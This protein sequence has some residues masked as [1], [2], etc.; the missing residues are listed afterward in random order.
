MG[1]ASGI[2]AAYLPSKFQPPPKTATSKTAHNKTFRRRRIP[3]PP[4]FISTNPTHVNP[5]HLRDLYT[6]SN[7]SCHRFPA[8][9]AD[10]RP[11]PVDL[12]KLRIA[13]SHSCIVVSVF[14]KPEVVSYYSSSSSENTMGFGG[15]WLRRVV[16]V[17]AENG[18]L[19]GFGRAVSDGGLTAAIYDV[20]VI[21]SL[22]EMGIG[23]M[24]VK[25]II[26]MLTSRGIY[27]IAALCSH[28]ER[29]FFEACGFGEDSLGATTMMYTRT[30]S[31]CEANHMVKHVGRKLL[32]APLVREPFKP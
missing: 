23:K 3:P 22:R 5:H 17:T 13:L 6:L 16:P 10:G 26:S 28:E 24:I 29:S 15:D 21:P 19:V 30:V 9:G 31:S 27:D 25:R 7:H 4:L 8:L 20:V 32:V 14:A 1:V 2:H 11:D 18:M 12:D